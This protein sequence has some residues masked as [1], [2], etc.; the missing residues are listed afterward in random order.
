MKT[1]KLSLALISVLV[2]AAI[3]LFAYLAPKHGHSVTLH[4]AASAGATSYNVYRGTTS[5]GP[6]DKVGTASTPTFVDTD[7]ESGEVLYYVVTAVKEGKESR[8]STE[9]KATVP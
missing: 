1:S 5:G 8:H 6:Y 2:I 9:I 7:V 3:A 4:W